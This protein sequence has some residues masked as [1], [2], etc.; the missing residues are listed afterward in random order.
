MRTRPSEQGFT[1]VEIMVVLTIVG[2]TAAVAMIGF[3]GD[4]GAARQ[5]A[6]RLGAR[7]LAAKDHALFS[8]RPTSVVVDASGYRFEE[9]RR[10]G[11]VPLNDRAMKPH[12]WTE[13]RP[14]GVTF[15][16]RVRFDA[17]GLSDPV[18]ITFHAGE[19]RALL[20]VGAD[21]EVRVET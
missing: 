16:V 21:G 13:V 17:V 20:K 4:R 18:T 7:M 15:P 8:Q 5:E 10:E 6:E 1:L 19:S 9:R 12:S 3:T 11:W 14:A 2:L